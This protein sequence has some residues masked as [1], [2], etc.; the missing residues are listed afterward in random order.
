MQSAIVQ[1]SEGLS[2]PWERVE[3]ASTPSRSYLVAEETRIARGQREIGPYIYRSRRPVFD[4][5]CAI[6]LKQRGAKSDCNL[7]DG[8]TVC[9][10]AQ[11]RHY[12]GDGYSVRGDP[13]DDGRQC[14]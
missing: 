10:H 11:L 5:V 6:Q 12:L 1:N 8:A 3:R 2:Q 13:T 7:D 4:G 9:A 14:T